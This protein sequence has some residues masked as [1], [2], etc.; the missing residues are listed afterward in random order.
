[1]EQS[2]GRKQGLGQN[3]KSIYSS[4]MVEDGWDEV[5]GEKQNE[6]KV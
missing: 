6:T 5:R 2:V 1:M 3:E 4:W